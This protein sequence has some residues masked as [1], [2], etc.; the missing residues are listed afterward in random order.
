MQS[1]LGRIN[2]NRRLISC[3]NEI[4]KPLQQKIKKD[5]LFKQNQLEWEAFEKNKST[6]AIT[7]ALRS[8]DFK[9][10]FL[11]YTFG[12][13]HSPIDVLVQKDEEGNEFPISSMSIKL[14]GSDLNYLDI[15]TKAYVVVK[16]IKQFKPYMLKNHTKVIISHS[17]IRSLFIQKEFGERRGSWMVSFQE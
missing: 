2:S 10:N 8:L 9:K 11:L 16:K 5:A 6:I 1:F 4:V 17:T 12:S 3:F 7:L 13:N 15:D 14:Q